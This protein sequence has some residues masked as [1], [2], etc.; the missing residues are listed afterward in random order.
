MNS[1]NPDPIKEG[2]HIGHSLAH[3]KRFPPHVQVRKH[4][5]ALHDILER[6]QHFLERN[7]RKYARD[8]AVREFG[9]RRVNVPLQPRQPVDV[10]GRLLVSFVLLQSAYQLRAR[11]LF[12]LAAFRRASAGA[13]AT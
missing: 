2:E 9:D 11:V 12:L 4:R 3:R 7:L 8:L 5:G 10:L 6:N 13:S 1:T